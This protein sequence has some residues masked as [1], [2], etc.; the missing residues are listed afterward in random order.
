MVIHAISLYDAVLFVHIL[1]VVVA[2]GVTFTYGLLDACARR[3][4]IVDMVALHRFQVFLSRRLITPAM[5]VVLVAGLYLTFDGPYELGDPW[6]GA[7]LTI[8]IVIFGLV[9]AVLTPAERRMLA[10]PSAA[11]RPAAASATS[12]P[13]SRAGT[14][15]RARLA[16]RG[17]RD[18]PDDGEAGRLIAARP[19]RAIWKESAAVGRN[20]CHAQS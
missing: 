7:T 18:L 10:M 19:G 13:P 14:R 15:R 9:G 8:L 17:G 6:I 20:P 12:T 5:V 2:F 16:A 3:A 11:L 4:G 1:A